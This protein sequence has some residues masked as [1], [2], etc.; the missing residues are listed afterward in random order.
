MT[1]GTWIEAQPTRRLKGGRSA[2][3]SVLLLN[4]SRPSI[5]VGVHA[6]VFLSRDADVIG[7]DGSAPNEALNAR[8]RTVCAV[9]IDPARG[10]R[11]VGCDSAAFVVRHADLVAR[12][13]RAPDEALEARARLDNL[14]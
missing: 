2:L 3:R 7:R 9:R 4:A 10:G 14:P 6:I 11:V 12:I 5:V 13:R 1:L 8:V